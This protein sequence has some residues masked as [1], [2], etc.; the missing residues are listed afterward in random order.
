MLVEVED[1]DGQVVVLTKGDGGGVH[2]FQALLQD[3]HVGDVLEFRGVFHDHRIGV[4]DAV[5][6]GGFDDDFSLDFHGAQR[7]SRVS[8]K[9]G[10]AGASGKDD[11]S[12]FFEVAHGAA[13]DKR[14]RDL[15][16][17]DGGHHAGVDILFFE[18]VLQSQ[19]I[20]DGGEHAHVIGGNA[21]HV[22][23][24]VGDAAE[25]VATTHDN[26]D[27][28]AEAVHVR[29]LGGDF[30]DAGGIYAESLPGCQGFTG[31]LEQDAFENW[32]RHEES[33]RFPVLS[34]QYTVTGTAG[35]SLRSG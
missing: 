17:F 5:D 9:I 2:D 14:F 1:D 31:D 32:S 34:S 12:S 4:V 18:R 7:R 27:L 6:L 35:P 23:R 29:Q 24:L 10:I 25:E 8:R 15:I 26:R 20:D 21:V 11:N 28:N 16:H 19:R 13:P 30:V 22:F 33:S 3:V